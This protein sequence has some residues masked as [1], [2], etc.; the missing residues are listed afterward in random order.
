MSRDASWWL[1]PEAV[2]DVAEVI[3]RDAALR[4]VSGV[5]DIERRWGAVYVPS[6]PTGKGYERLLSSV[7]ED[8]AETLVKRFGGTELRFGSCAA[9][10]SRVRDASVREHWR[11]GPLSVVWIG[12]LHDLTER[13]VRNITAG[14]PR[15]ERAAA[16]KAERALAASARNRVRGAEQ[17]GPQRVSVPASV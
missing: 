3:G 17:R 11:N 6:S 14:M 12:W 15:L 8:H 9:W 4:L 1:L 7:G 5:F 10:V 16:L 2:R 13:Q